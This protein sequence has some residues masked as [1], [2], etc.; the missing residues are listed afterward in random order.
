MPRKQRR[1]VVGDFV[2]EDRD[3]FAARPA[4]AEPPV[5]GRAIARRNE[6]E[7]PTAKTP[8]PDDPPTIVLTVDGEFRVLKSEV[9]PDE[10][11]RLTIGQDVTEGQRYRVLMN[12]NGQIVLD[13]V[14]TIPTRELWLLRNHEAFSS[15]LRGIHQAQAG[16]LNYLGSFAEDIEGNE[17]LDGNSDDND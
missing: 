6:P 4:V 9:Q 3:S 7:S 13:P 16:Q 2:S 1:H 10:R 17:D 11:G 15:V 14:V 8:S 12:A 5:A